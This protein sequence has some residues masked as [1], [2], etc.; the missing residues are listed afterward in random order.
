MLNK[1]VSDPH[2]LSVQ[3]SSLGARFQL[4]SLCVKFI[5]A[6]VCDPITEVMLRDRLYAAGFTWFYYVPMWYSY[7]SNT[8]GVTDGRKELEADVKLL[9]DFCK[10][11]VEKV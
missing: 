11:L 10:A 8:E 4:L 2:S 3:P 7:D 6:G 1:A 5:Q 9:I